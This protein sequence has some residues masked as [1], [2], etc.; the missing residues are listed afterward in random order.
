MGKKFPQDRKTYISAC[1][2]CNLYLQYIGIQ[3]QTA[4]C[5]ICSLFLHICGEGWKNR[6]LLHKSSVFMKNNMVAEGSNAHAAC[7]ESF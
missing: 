3:G 4:F 7:S 5:V 6:E 1:I 2:L